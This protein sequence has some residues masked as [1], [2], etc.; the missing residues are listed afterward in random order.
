MRSQE[1]LAIQDRE[2]PGVGLKMGGAAALRTFSVHRRSAAD[3]MASEKNGCVMISIL[4]YFADRRARFVAQY[5]LDFH[6]S[7]FVM[8]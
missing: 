2:V 8:V 6:S 5:H 4:Y 7:K 3:V 1:V